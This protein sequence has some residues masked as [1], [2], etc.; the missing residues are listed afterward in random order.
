[1]GAVG[2]SLLSAELIVNRI[3]R[4]FGTSGFGLNAGSRTYGGAI[5]KLPSRSSR[6]GTSGGAFAGRAHGTAA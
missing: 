2:K 4:P 3:T 1:M 5:R 6:T